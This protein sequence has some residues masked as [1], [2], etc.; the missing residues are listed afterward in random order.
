MLQ[1]T[2]GSGTAS[3]PRLAICPDRHCYRRRPVRNLADS[4]DIDV[5]EVLPTD[6]AT[7]DPVLRAHRF[8]LVRGLERYVDDVGPSYTR[9][10]YERAARDPATMVLA[11]RSDQRV[12]AATTISPA[13]W[14]SGLLGTRVG[15]LG[16]VVGVAEPGR[17]EPA[18]RR[19]LEAA[20]ARW[21]EA[22]GG[23]LVARIDVDDADAVVAAQRAGFE[24]LETTIAYLNDND[25]E[26]GTTHAPRG[27]EVRCHPHGSA[28]EIPATALDVLMRSVDETDRI[29]H[30]YSDR[31]LDPDR[32]Q[33]LYRAWVTN[34]FRGDHGDVVYTAWRD[35]Q[36]LGVLSWTEDGDLDELA[37]I[38]VLRS[39]FGAVAPEGHGAL[40]DLYAAVCRDR[41][42]GSRLVESTTQA[43][44]EAVFTVWGRFASM[45]PASANY[46]LHGWF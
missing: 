13:A 28:G 18:V 5:N 46:V 4:S 10:A 3:D 34:T 14:E 45:R 11:A 39:G 38:K 25:A 40:G 20:G 36:V 26:P 44:N 37:G 35:D 29:G 23:M 43:G 33:D 16:D 30:L 41:P 32:V 9:Q 42:L 19:L 21:A 24:V 8:S 31:A 17:R 1:P 15:H 6:L 22:G 12:L 27:F 7:L 2:S